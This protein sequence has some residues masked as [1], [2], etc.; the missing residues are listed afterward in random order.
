MANYSKVLMFLTSA[1]FVFP[2]LADPPG[3]FGSAKDTAQE[4]W[5]D[6]GPSS[7]YCHCPYRLATP[8]E[9]AIRKGNLWVIASVCG[10]QADDLITSKGKPNARAMR[11]EWEHIVPA[12]WIATG[13]NCQEMKRDECRQIDGF[14]EA[15]GDLFNLVPAVGEMNGD[16]SARP[17]GLIDG[18]ERRYGACDFEV[19]TTGVGE[20][21]IRG[22]AEPMPSIRGD[23]AR[24]WLYMHD[25]YGVVLSPEYKALLESW[26]AADPVDKAERERH[27]IIAK[28]MGWENPFVAGQ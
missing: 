26:S 21:H 18:E 16:R 15:E 10:Y 4:L 25:R 3:D 5:W 6:V 1:F 12:D 2:A 11:I 23:A 22:A 28:E 14:K 9:K 13:F 20:P 24:V 7:F 27:G 8:E 17:Y 19:K